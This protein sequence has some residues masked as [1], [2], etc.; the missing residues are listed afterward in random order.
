MGTR[1]VPAAEFKATC[2][3]IIREM[4][5]DGRAVTITRRGRPVALLSPLP[6]PGGQPFIG[7]MQGTV[8]AYDDPFAPAAPPSDW[9]ALRD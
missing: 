5:N 4:E 2:L 7:K 1:R 9:S 8:L 6:A 3:R